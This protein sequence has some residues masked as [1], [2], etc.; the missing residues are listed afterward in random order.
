MKTKINFLKLS[1]AALLLFVSGSAFSA[2]YYMCTGASLNMTPDA[3]PAGT[4]YLWDVQQGGV[5]IAGYPSTTKPTTLG[6]A[7]SYTVILN[8]VLDDV[9]SAGICPP[10][11]V[12]NTVIV[13]PALTITLGTPSNPIYCAANNAIKSSDISQTTTGFLPAYS[14]DLDAEVTYSVVKDSDAPVD[15]ATLGTID[16]TTGKYTLTTIIPGVY[17]ITA[18]VKYK[19]KAGATGTLLGT[20]GCPATSTT[21]TV[22]VSPKPTSPAITFS[23]S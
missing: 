12:T 7:G 2:T 23:A 19:Q 4:H 10:D 15:G 14:S 16:A 5:S 3:A 20:T 22:T 17:K 13:L 8:T 6:T 11:F 9:T 18:T 21:Q 1:F